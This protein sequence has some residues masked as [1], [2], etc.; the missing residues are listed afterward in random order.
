[1]PLKLFCLAKPDDDVSRLPVTSPTIGES[2]ILSIRTTDL[3]ALRW[4][5]DVGEGSGSNPG[6]GGSAKRARAE[7]DASE[8]N[9]ADVETPRKEVMGSFKSK[10][11]S[12]S[13]PSSWIDCEA[14]SGKLNIEQDDILVSNGP[15]GPMMKLSPKLK[16]QLHKPWANALILKNMGRFHTLGFMTT[17]LT[18]KWNLVGQWHLTDL[19]E[20]GY[21]VVRFQLKED[22]EYVLTNGPWVIMNQYLAVQ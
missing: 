12:M 21:F 19:G 2:F 4:P 22:L 14:N 16:D 1:M 13:C 5:R 7:S 6:I 9:N 20:E 18:Q 11:M 10:L 15:S 8:L 17:K 3:V